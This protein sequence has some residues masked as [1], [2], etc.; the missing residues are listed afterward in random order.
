MRIIAILISPVM[1]KAAHGIFDQL[2]WKM[3]LSGKKNDFLSQ[4][5][6]GGDCRTDMSSANRSRCFRGLSSMKAFEEQLLGAEQ[7]GFCSPRRHSL[8]LR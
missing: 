5:R 4:T 6:S 8:R 3:E 2:N 1:P 7:Q